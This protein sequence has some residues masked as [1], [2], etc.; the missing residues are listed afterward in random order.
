[1]IDGE[2]ILWTGEMNGRNQSERTGVCLFKRGFTGKCLPS[3]RFN[4][5]T[6]LR[7]SLLN[8]TAFHVI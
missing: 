4:P 2:V 1:L 3:F 6:A 5:A 8:Q 7:I